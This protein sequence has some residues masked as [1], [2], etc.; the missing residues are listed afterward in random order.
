MENLQGIPK[1]AVSST[2]DLTRQRTNTES[3]RDWLKTLA[4][5]ALAGVVGRGEDKLLKIPE[6]IFLEPDKQT[7]FL[8]DEKTEGDLAEPAH[9]PL[10]AVPAEPEHPS[11]RWVDE[12]ERP[13]EAPKDVFPQEE[14][15]KL[16]IHIHPT[17]DIGLLL[18]RS[19]LKY[20]PLV[21]YAKEISDRY[22]SQSEI[23]PKF[24]LDIVLLDQERMTGKANELPEEIC[25]LKNFYEKSFT[26]DK[27]RGG[28]MPYR[29]KLPSEVAGIGIIDRQTNREVKNAVREGIVIFLCVGGDRRPQMQFSVISPSILIPSVPLEQ[30]KDEQYWKSIGV[31]SYIPSTKTTGEAL[32]HEWVGHFD[33]N[34]LVSS[35]EMKA[36]IRAVSSLVE[37]YNLWR[38]NGD[39]SKYYFVFT[40]PEGPIYTKSEDQNRS[41]M[42]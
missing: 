29:Y 34:N 16:N 7:F 30:A 36:D 11:L 19:A 21:Q 8:V 23:S 35:D 31:N 39:L 22:A 4:G 41:Q 9:E 33:P 3:R 12:P 32:R 5:A 1:K 28:F 13:K 26:N 15:R 37:A 2:G 17:K 18:Q 40:T 6:P 10:K 20:D 24:R 25:W 27:A 14:L 42:A 38:A